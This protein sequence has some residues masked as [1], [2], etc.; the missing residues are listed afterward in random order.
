MQDQRT[1]YEILHVQPDAP[2]DIIKS[3]Y[4]TLMQQLNAH[5][6][7]GGDSTEAALIN[8]AYAVLS[9]TAKRAN[10]DTDLQLQTPLDLQADASPET[11]E[12]L[13]LGVCLFCGQAH[14][15]SDEIPPD[16]FCTACASP[17]SPADRE[18]VEQSGQRKV[19]RIGKQ[20]AITWYAKWPQKRP[21]TGKLINLS[22]HGLMFKTS[23]EVARE[24]RIR[25]DSGQFTSIVQVQ[26]CRP[27]GG[28]L[29]PKWHIGG[30]FLTIRFNSSSGVF[31]SD[32]A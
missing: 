5:P 6:D 7:R 12:L 15:Y 23:Q 16:T 2:F 25:V 32:K 22:P 3:S 17:L 10:Y 4:R 29:R 8:R 1:Y 21:A 9:D 14:Q 18:R 28:I 13:A 19:E 30:K 31:V 27:A 24:S 20:S 11:I 26:N